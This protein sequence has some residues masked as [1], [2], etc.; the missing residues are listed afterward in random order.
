MR[1]VSNR[2]DQKVKNRENQKKGE[3]QKKTLNQPRIHYLVEIGL[4]DSSEFK[5]LLPVKNQLV[6][7]YGN[8]V[9]NILKI[10]IE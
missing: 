1:L 6:E 9:S 5:L 2:E 7:H 10:V 8:I 3:K 4:I